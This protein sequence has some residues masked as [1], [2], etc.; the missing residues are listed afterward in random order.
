LWRHTPKERKR[1]KKAYQTRFNSDKG[2]NDDF[3]D[4]YRQYI[5]FCEGDD[6]DECNEA[7]EALVL[8]VTADNDFEEQDFNCFVTTF[9]TLSAS[10]AASV[11]AELANKACAHLLTTPTDATEADPFVYSTTAKSRYTSTVFVGIMVDTD[12]SKESTADY[13]Q[14]QALQRVDQTIRLDTLTKGQVSVQFGISM[15]FS[16]ETVEVDS[17]IGKVHFY[18]V[19]ANTP[20][21]LCLADID[22]LQVYYNNL[23][24]IIIT[25]TG[26][27]QVVRRFGYLFLLW[28][29]ALQ[30]YL[31]ES[32]NTNP[33]YL[34]NVKLQRLHRRF[35]HPLVKRL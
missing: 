30:S 17:L 13:R 14:F 4:R 33:C 7:F 10:E 8:D 12:A 34:T 20:F 29:L 32:F 19:H 16:I 6:K 18:V 26:A 22:S 9:G 35:G 15:A 23:K 2:S 1:F 25:H 5:V 28:N 3:E 24:D 31:A 11:S 21:L 27:V